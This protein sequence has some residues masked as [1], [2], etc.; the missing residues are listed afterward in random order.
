M[1]KLMS[2]I[3]VVRAKMMVIYQERLVLLNSW[4]SEDWFWWADPKCYNDHRGNVKEANDL[5]CFPYRPC[6]I[7]SK[8]QKDWEKGNPI[9][10]YAKDNNTLNQT[11]FNLLN[12]DIDQDHIKK[13][14][15][16]LWTEIMIN[17][18]E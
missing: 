10:Q 5:V 2:E 7:C 4:S 6:P 3:A 9:V 11:I 15:V 1:N 14:E 12:L 17:Q 16:M 18:E 8:N 13:R